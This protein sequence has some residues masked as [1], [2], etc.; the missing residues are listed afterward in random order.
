MD[1][2]WS[3]II[4]ETRLDLARPVNYLD[5][6]LVKKYGGKDV[7]LLLKIDSEEKSPHILREHGVFFLPVSRK[8]IVI[9]KGKG[10]HRIEDLP[11]S[12]EIFRTE[13][14]F[15]ASV[16]HSTG[17][18]RYIDYAY[19]SGLL[20]K[21]TGRSGL[22]LGFRGRRIASFTFRVDGNGPFSVNGAQIEVD[23]SFEDNQKLMLV[24]GK[25]RLPASFNIRQLYYPFKTFYNEL[26]EKQIENIFFVYDPERVEYCFW[27]YGFKD[28]DDYEKIELLK[29]G[30]FK[31]EPITLEKPLMGYDVAP[32]EMGA[33]Q[34]NDIYKLMELPFLIIEGTDDAKRVAMYFQFDVRQSSYYRQ[35]MERLG[36]IR[37][38]GTKYVLTEVGEQYIKMPPEGRTKFFLKKLFEYPMVN[39]VVKMLLAGEHISNSQL[40]AIVGKND[41]DISKST[42]PRRASTIRNWFKWIAD[43]TGYCRVDDDY[44]RP[45]TAKDTLGHYT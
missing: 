4:R 2:S 18:A 29:G 11:K 32:V 25:A 22:H 44:I 35:G 31:I 33:I 8:R 27:E 26:K 9:V 38:R 1:E 15:P 13:F 7:R 43:N 36:F 41:P 21:F 12:P 16:L 42:I 24:E 14:S 6:A 5:M 3:N 40:N 20:G 39:E 19:S 30:R 23:S 37:E 10:F 17:E 45:F 28:P 34:A